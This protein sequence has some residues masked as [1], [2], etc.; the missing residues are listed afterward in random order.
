MLYDLGVLLSLDE[1]LSQVLDSEYPI[2]TAGRH[3][4]RDVSDELFVPAFLQTSPRNG[5]GPHQGPVQE[6]QPSASASMVIRACQ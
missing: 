2:I 3:P 5:E 6:L 4:S 1:V